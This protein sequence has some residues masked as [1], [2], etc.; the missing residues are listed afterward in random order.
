MTNDNK[1]KKIYTREGDK[2]ETSLIGG[3]RVPK[4]TTRIEAYGT[5]DELNCVVGMLR[6]QK[7]SGNFSE[8]LFVIQDRLFIIESLLAS[9]DDK[10][11][12]RLPH[13]SDDDITFLENQIDQMNIGMPELNNFIIPG[14][15]TVV[16]WAHIARTVCRRA[17]RR[18]NKLASEE[19][20]QDL[21]LRYINRLSDY[22]FVLA[23]RLAFDLGIKDNIWMP[24]K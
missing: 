10:V 1:E 17:E 3:H 14:G 22:F 19:N 11:I 15:H 20:I 21:I 24:Y 5:V 8:P 16:S 18:I 12:K 6:D 4:H 9:P 13:I 7:E 23:R 2:G